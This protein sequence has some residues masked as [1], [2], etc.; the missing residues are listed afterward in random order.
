MFLIGD[1]LT[2]ADIAAVSLLGWLNIRIPDHQWETTYPQLKSYWEHLEKRESFATTQPKPQT[3][4][5]QIV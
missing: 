2:L 5:D 4:K 3:M 1:K